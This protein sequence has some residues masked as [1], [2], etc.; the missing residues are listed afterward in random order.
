MQVDLMD[1][2]LLLNQG[3]TSYVADDTMDGSGEQMNVQNLTYVFIIK[4]YSPNANKTSYC[5]L[6]KY[7]IR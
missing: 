3:D 4:L 7:D 5:P 6:G 1:V 2:V